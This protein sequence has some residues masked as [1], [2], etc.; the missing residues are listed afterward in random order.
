MRDFL[1][2]FRYTFYEHVRKKTFIIST[3]ILVALAVVMM[4]LPSIISAVQQGGKPGGTPGTDGEPR[5]VLYVLDADDLLGGEL[6]GLRAVS[7]GYEVKTAEPADKDSLVGRIAEEDGLFLLEIYLAD[8]KPAAEYYFRE[9]ATGP[10]PDALSTA[11]KQ[12]YEDILLRSAGVGEDVIA[13]LRAPLQLNLHE[14]GSGYFKGQI[15]SILICLLLFISI[16]YYGYWIAQSVAS[17]KTS[18]VMEL[19]IT[20]VKPSSIIVGKT[21]AMGALGLVQLAILLFSGGLTY[22]IAFPKDFTVLGQQLDLSAFTPVAVIM[23]LVYFLLGYA[24]F[25]M[26]NAVAGASVSRAEDINTAIMP[27]SFIGIASFY[28]AY[29][30]SLIPGAGR[31]SVIAS[32]VPFS[33]PFSMP[34]RILSAGA[35]AGELLLSLVLLA[36]TILA[37]AWVSIRLYSSAVLHYGKRLK[38]SELVGLARKQR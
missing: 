1:T 25:A 3:I 36:V 4:L 8:E 23:I 31:L 21:A 7:T 18:R 34:S 14:R 2:V 19:L 9:Y 28:F 37:L 20:S 22:R 12:R 16:Y 33:A 17:E 35:H 5:G 15:S 24:L 32:I 11:I 30:T 38:I 27:I 10:D 26:L 29:M 6:D 13:R